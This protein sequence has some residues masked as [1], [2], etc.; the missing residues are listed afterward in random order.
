MISMQFLRLSDTTEDNNDD[1]VVVDDD[2]DDDAH[3]A[4]NGSQTTRPLKRNLSF[5]FQKLFSYF[6][7]NDLN[8]DFHLNWREAVPLPLRRLAVET[9]K[10]ARKKREINGKPTCAVDLCRSLLAACSYLCYANRVSLVTRPQAHRTH[11]ENQRERERENCQSR[12]TIVKRRRR[13]RSA[14]RLNVS[15]AVPWPIVRYVQYVD[16]NNNKV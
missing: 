1:V 3:S 12:G 5:L 13:I 4:V 14:V 7:A 2:Y 8:Y 9:R 15:A 6:M 10:R 11:T 16:E